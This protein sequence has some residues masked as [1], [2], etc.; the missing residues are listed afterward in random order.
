MQPDD[1]PLDVSASW[2]ATARLVYRK[3]VFR[4]ADVEGT[5]A[6]IQG[7]AHRQLLYIQAVADVLDGVF[8]TDDNLA[9]KLAALHW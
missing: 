6:A 3:A 4:Q 5:P 9:L 1:H 2:G 8:P 7:D